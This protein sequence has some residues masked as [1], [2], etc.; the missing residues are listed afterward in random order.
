MFNSW[1]TYSGIVFGKKNLHFKD[2]EILRKIIYYLKDDKN[3]LKPSCFSGVDSIGTSEFRDGRFRV[4]AV[5]P[6]SQI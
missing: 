1:S 6:H 2:F 5:L 4:A 3:L